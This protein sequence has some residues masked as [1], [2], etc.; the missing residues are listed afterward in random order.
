[1]SRGPKAG[2]TVASGSQ[3]FSW[4]ASRGATGYQWCLSTTNG[5][6]TAWSPVTTSRSVK[7]V[8]AAGTTYYWQVRAVNGI[9]TTD[10]DAGSWWSVATR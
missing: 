10:A 6:C 9:G 4:S 1:M 3:T 7:L 8:L 2:A 5:S